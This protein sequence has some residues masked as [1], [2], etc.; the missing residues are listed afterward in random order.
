VGWIVDLLVKPDRMDVAQILVENALAHFESQNI[1]VVRYWVI[2]GSPYEE[3]MKKC[4]FLDIKKNA[5]EVATR[6]RNIGDNYNVFLK[7]EPSNL[8][9]QI[10][11]TEL[12]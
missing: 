8:H 1:N 4:L 11:D 12:I 7:S 6:P 5:P 2:K 3:V 10:G 9:I